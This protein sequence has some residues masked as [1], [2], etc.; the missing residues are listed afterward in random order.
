MGKDEEIRP[1]GNRTRHTAAFG[2]RNYMEG[3][4]DLLC[5]SLDTIKS[6]KR[7][8]FAKIGATN[9]SQALARATNYELL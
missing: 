1:N 4:A 9:I 2:T 7:N 5:K 3:I 6:H 8:L